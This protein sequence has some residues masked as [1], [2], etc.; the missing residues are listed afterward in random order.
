MNLK[1]LVVSAVCLAAAASFGLANMNAMKRTSVYRTSTVAIIVSMS[2][3]YLRKGSGIS[4]ALD[5]I[6]TILTNGNSVHTVGTFDGEV[7]LSQVMIAI[8]PAKGNTPEQTEAIVNAIVED[9]KSSIPVTEGGEVRYPGEQEA[10]NIE[11]FSKELASLADC[12]VDDAFGSCHR[13]HCSTEGVTKFLSPCVAGYLIG[14]GTPA[15]EAVAQVG[16]VEGYINSRT[17]LR[18]ANE[19]KIEVP[20]IDQIVKICFEGAVP[21]NSIA[22]LMGRAVKSER[23]TYW[24]D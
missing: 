13:A 4:I 24:T 5:L 20:I 15:A 12:Y 8:D 1:K 6:A 23:E 21:T 14:K 9:V 3:T 2:T 7:G 18:L 16:T 17:A 19:H 10:R 22:A 11:D